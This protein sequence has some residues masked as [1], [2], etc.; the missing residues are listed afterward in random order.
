MR[1]HPSRLRGCPISPPRQGGTRAL[2]TRSAP[3]RPSGWITPGTMW[4][5]LCICG[6]LIGC[7]LAAAELREGSSALLGKRLLI[8]AVYAGLETTAILLGFTLLH[9]PLRLGVD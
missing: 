2:A 3:A 4:A 6:L 5:G 1:R 7:G 8:V 9:K